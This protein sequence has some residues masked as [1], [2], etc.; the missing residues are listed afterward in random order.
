MDWKKIHRIKNTLE[1][2]INYLRSEWLWKLFFAV[3]L[4]LQNPRQ[5]Y[6]H[7]IKGHWIEIW[8]LQNPLPIDQ[9]KAKVQY[10]DYKTTEELRISYPELAKLDLVETD[11]I[12]SAENLE[13]IETNSKDFVIL[14]HVFE[15]LA[16]PIKAL[17]EF[18]RVLRKDG[19]AFL[20][21][22]EKTRTFDKNRPRTALEHI[23]EDYKSPSQERDYEHF[24]E[25]A[26]IHY[27]DAASQEKEAKRLRD[28]NY[29]I[30]YHV[31]IEE[32]VVN[33]VNRCNE[34]WITHFSI[35]D[36]KSLLRNPADNEFILIL[37]KL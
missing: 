17:Q 14:N 15:H 9:D 30:H 13:T 35:I 10:V 27:S 8:A 4:K 31:F 21:I 11:Y 29:S 5:K 23:I 3:L 2:G 22:P 24:R 36:K 18:D 34:Q 25:F 1:A 7:H 19:I 28:T 37:K 33:L 12:G 16:N 32:D 6:I 20:A 26:W